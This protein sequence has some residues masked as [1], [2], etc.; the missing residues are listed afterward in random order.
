M[1]RYWKLYTLTLIIL[2]AIGIFY[3][4]PIFSNSE[5]PN[6]TIKTVEGDSTEIKGLTLQGYYSP[7][8]QYQEEFGTMYSEKPFSLNNKQLIYDKQT[9]FFSQ[10]SYIDGTSQLDRLQK[11]H[12]N[13]LRGKNLQTQ[14][15]FE[16]DSFLIYINLNQ[17][18]LDRHSGKSF[19]DISLLNKKT[20]E[21]LSYKINL[22]IKKEYQYVDIQK[23]Q[24]INSNLSVVTRNDFLQINGQEY[25]ESIQEYHIYQLDLGNQKIATDNLI[26]FDTNTSADNL[27][28]IEL[29]SETAIDQISNDL[30][31]SLSYD[32]PFDEAVESQLSPELLGNELFHYKISKN[33]TN[34]IPL[35]KKMSTFDSTISL[36]KD[37]IYSYRFTDD[38]EINLY[39][40]SI[41][42]LSKS[43]EKTI[44]FS[45]PEDAIEWKSIIN[46]KL[47]LVSS[48]K[49]SLLKKQL[50]IYDLAD[51]KLIYE[52]SIEPASGN[53]LPKKSGLRFDYGLVE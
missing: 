4:K 32:Q 17:E 8:A 2:L 13:F 29:I 50:F 12:K 16:D 1:K 36:D 19:F 6:F 41:T 52:G 46:N 23:I 5:Y 43:T 40:T 22:P 11:E 45:I 14:N 30:I 49:Q 53:S 3:L 10:L 31:F 47:Y 42:D 18:H 33:E 27:T 20:D 15:F 28:R 21:R 48:T 24:I 25:T 35:P 9:S 44:D 38:D 34:K 51:E 26:S 39:T 37:M 7:D